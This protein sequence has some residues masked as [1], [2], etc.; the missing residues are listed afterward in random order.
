M[1]LNFPWDLK[2]K[3]Y[4]YIV[5]IKVPKN[6]KYMSGDGEEENLRI[7]MVLSSCTTNASMFITINTQLFSTK[8]NISLIIRTLN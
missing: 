4:L 6:H 5:N 1:L 8:D 7:L 3:K 2:K